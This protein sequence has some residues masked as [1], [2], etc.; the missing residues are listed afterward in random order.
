MKKWDGLTISRLPM[1]HAEGA[2]PMQVHYAMSVFANQGVLMQPQLVKK[3]FDEM[4]ETIA[5]FSPKAKRRVVSVRAA[6]TVRTFLSEA[7]VGGT[8]RKADLQEF[9]IAGK[10]GTTQKIINGK[11]SHTHH[12]ASFSGFFP[13]ERPQVVVTVVIDEPQ[14]KGCGYGGAVAAP[15]FK[16]IAEQLVQYLGIQPEKDY[17]TMLAWRANGSVNMN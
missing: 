3:V 6:Q 17:K 2:T 11:Y 13:A 1:G 14:L 10:T 16:K 9:T 4:G 5:D 7:T 8:G 12:V 15:V